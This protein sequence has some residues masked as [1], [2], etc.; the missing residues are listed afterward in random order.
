MA[1]KTRIAASAFFA[2]VTVLLCVLWVRSYW[3]EQELFLR[4]NRNSFGVATA[5]PG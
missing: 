3:T 1:R 2:V 4:M 5:A